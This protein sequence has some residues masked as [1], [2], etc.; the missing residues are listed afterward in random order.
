MKKGFTLI[1]LLIVVAIIA[2]LAA[3]A[4]PNFLEAQTRSKVSRVKADHRSMATAIETYYLDNNQ[5]PMFYGGTGA[6]AGARSANVLANPGA[7]TIPVELS[8]TFALAPAGTNVPS[9][10]TTPI[11][12]FTSYPADP[13]ADTRGLP[14][15][16]Y[17]NSRGFIIGS[18]GPDADQ[19]SLTAFTAT[20]G[21]LTVPAGSGDLEWALGTYAS[22]FPPAASPLV[23]GLGVSGTIFSG[24]ET[25]YDNA[26][27]G[28]PQFLLLQTYDPTNGTTSSG[29]VWRIRD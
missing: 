11:S 14:F 15:R 2:I 25:Y 12:Y 17:S 7:A 16:Y 26:V 8:R 23:A 20:G 10:I 21:N 4:V 27:T 9:T 1:E 28:S 5:Y 19:G 13:F 22:S 3:I 24:A 29:D 18:F 6:P